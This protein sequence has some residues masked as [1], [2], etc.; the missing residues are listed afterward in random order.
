MNDRRRLTF[1]EEENQRRQRDKSMTPRSRVEWSLRVL[2]IDTIKEL[3]DQFCACL[4]GRVAP[5][6]LSEDAK[7]C[8]W[9]ALADEF[10]EDPDDDLFAA[11]AT[12]DDLALVLRPVA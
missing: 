7:R 9:R 12:I 10:G 1:F 6:D 8:L 3:A 11:A 4:E 5:K 2:S